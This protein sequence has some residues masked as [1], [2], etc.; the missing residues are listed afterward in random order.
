[1]SDFQLLRRFHDQGDA[2]AFR[3][4]V[5]VHAGMVFAT[6]RRVT[7]DAA[8]AEDVAQ[9]TFL[10]LARSGGRIN[11]SVGAWLHR[12]AWRRACNAVRAA[13][14]R[15][16]YEEAAAAT[17][18]HTGAEASWEQLEPLIDE[19]LD[20][21]PEKLRMPLVEHF[22]AGR[23]QQEVAARLGVNQST[24]SRLIESGVQSLREQLRR[25]GLAVGAALALA[26]S[27]HAVVAPPPALTASL[28]KVAVAGVGTAPAAPRFHVA[29]RWVLLVAL[30]VGVSATAL[31]RRERH[32][33]SVAAEH[34]H[35]R[36]FCAGDH[37]QGASAHGVFVHQEQGGDVTYDLHLDEPA[38]DFHA[39]YCVPSMNDANAVLVE[40]R[41]ITRDGRRIF[42]ATS[43]RRSA[44]AP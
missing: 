36:A 44:P 24:V 1:M 31:L 41:V 39:Q 15:R 10:E 29:W 12:V 40:G 35:G 34:W 21:L 20:E 14:T 2:F 42:A 4:L 18:E 30:I 17:I 25:K 7:R 22:L 28:G 33:P 19:A 5:Q 13:G 8:L 6:A 37:R 3:E 16:R 11:E 38:E 27:A 23:T 43:I 32:H 9:E 26:L